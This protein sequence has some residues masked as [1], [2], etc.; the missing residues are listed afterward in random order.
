MDSNVRVTRK[1]VEGINEGGEGTVTG[2][3]Y[4]GVIW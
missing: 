2:Y 3:R 4:A 1:K